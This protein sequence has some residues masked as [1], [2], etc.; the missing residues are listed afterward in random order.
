LRAWLRRELAEQKR[1]QHESCRLTLW[2]FEKSARMEVRL[3]PVCE[4]SLSRACEPIFTRVIGAHVTTRRKE[5]C[6]ESDPC[7]EL[8]GS[9]AVRQ[10]IKPEHRAIN[11]PLPCCAGEWSAIEWRSVEIP[12]FKRIWL[13][14]RRE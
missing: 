11:L 3:E 8:H 2:P 13:F 9:A 14:G 7:T 6:P 10:R 12:S 1:K 4:E 5:H